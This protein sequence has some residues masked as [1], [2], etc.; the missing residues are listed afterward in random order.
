MKFLKIILFF[1]IVFCFLTQPAAAQKTEINV[2]AYSGFFTFWGNG[3]TTNSWYIL[4]ASNVNT[5]VYS[6]YG[7]KSAGFFSFEIQVQK[8]IQKNRI[9]GIGLSFETAK[10]RVNIDSAYTKFGGPYN[11]AFGPYGPGIYSSSRP[12]HIDGSLTLHNT[13]IT[14]NPFI[15]QRIF[16]KKITVDVLAGVD[17]AYGLKS[18]EKLHAAGSETSNNGMNY[19]VYSGSFTYERKSPS[20]DLRPGIKLKIQYQH[21]GVLLGYSLGITD[22]QKNNNDNPT[23]LD[24]RPNNESTFSSIVR[25]GIS[26]RIK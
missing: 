11:F 12:L 18:M 13:Y 24:V 26:W 20:V 15:G 2:N 22:Y 4:P 14:I 7:K 21:L 3:A 5:A 1:H 19:S 23:Y 25:L 9:Y 17:V 10:T 16:Y 8:V 6:P